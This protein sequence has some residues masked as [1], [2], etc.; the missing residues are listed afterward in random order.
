MPFDSG[1]DQAEGLRRLLESGQTRLVSVLSGKSR[2]G[3]TSATI[4]LAAA[5]TRSGK[6]VLVLDE[7]GAPNNV[8]DGLG[9][10]ARYD[11]LDVVQGKCTLR[12]ALLGCKG[13]AVLPAA[14][15]R[16]A[17]N[18]LGIAE[19]RRLEHTLAE[20]SNG[21]DVMLLDAALSASQAA[22]TRLDHGAAL[23]LVIDATT[24]G[25]TESYAL[26]KRLDMEYGR[27]RLEVLVNKVD[28]ERAALTVFANMAALA[29]RNLSTR[30]EYAG[31]IPRD[32]KLRHAG[33]LGKAV[34]DAF[35]NAAST[36]SFLGLANY[37]LN[38]PLRQDEPSVA[39]SLA[40]QDLLMRGA[41]SLTRHSREMAH[42]VN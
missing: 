19:Q 15:A 32:E 16:H 17:L 4:N 34:F 18:K 5:L 3:K 10:Y 20:V 8:L 7:N 37:V 11:L 13:F 29:R 21:V 41:P 42:V 38:L 2:V 6:D 35:P 22:V 14:R 40:I 24:S 28:D 25:I 36:P 39:A 9:L 23:L 12:Q 27:L 33:R 26:I 1:M 31:Y 30:L